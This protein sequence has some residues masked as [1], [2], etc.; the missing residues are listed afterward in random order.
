MKNPAFYIFFVLFAAI[1][2]APRCSDLPKDPIQIRVLSDQTFTGHYIVDGG[3]TNSIGGA[4]VILNGTVWEFNVEIEELDGVEV[5]ATRD[6]ASTYIKIMI[7]RDGN[8]V[9]E[10]QL[11]AAGSLVLTLE[12]TYDEENSSAEE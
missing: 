2:F 9:K 12:Y 6:A 10:K 8:K 11:D 3:P 1:L 5:L 4:D 7:Y